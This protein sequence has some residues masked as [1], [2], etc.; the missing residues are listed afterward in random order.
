MSNGVQQKLKRVRPP[1]VAITYDVETGGATE[2]KELP[3]VTGILADLSGD[4]KNKPAMSER[5]FTDIKKESIDSYMGSIK[6]QLNLQV[7]DKL[8]DTEDDGLR[9]NLEF[10]KLD[11]FTPMG[12]VA[13]VP[14]LWKLYQARVQLADLMSKLDGNERLND[15]L[16]EVAEKTDNLDA[17]R[18]ALGPTMEEEEN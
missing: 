14:S 3:F 12:L 5:K 8:S 18:T 2:Q 16:S 1:R 13:Q 17:L 11:D 4:N 10:N 9:V 15:L 6:P 7:Q